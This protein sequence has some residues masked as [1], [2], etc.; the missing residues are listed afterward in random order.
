M[1]ILAVNNL[2][3]SH[4]NNDKNKS[5]FLSMPCFGLVMPKPI[6][7]DTVSFKSGAIAQTKKAAGDLKGACSAASA[8]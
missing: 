8:L 4:V 1:N 3:I 5:A 2:R 7:Q 6:T